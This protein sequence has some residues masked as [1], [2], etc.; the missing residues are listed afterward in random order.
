MVM[1][2]GGELRGGR[3]CTGD[4]A[5]DVRDPTVT[6]KYIHAAS[7]I[8]FV[9]VIMIYVIKYISIVVV[10]ECILGPYRYL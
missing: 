4:G 6:G 9:G 5:T 8:K 7:I 1:G 3:L 10:V 2:W